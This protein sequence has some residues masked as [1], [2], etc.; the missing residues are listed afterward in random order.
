MISDFDRIFENLLRQ[1]LSDIEF[2]ISF[3]M[4]TK[5]FAPI[6]DNKNT[7]N[8]YLY[9][10]SENRE[11]RRVAPRL[12]TSAE[13]TVFST[14]SLFRV[15]LSYCITAWSPAQAIPSIS[16]ELDEHQLLTQVL[17][18]LLRYPE[19]PGDSDLLQG[20][21]ADLAIPI[22]TSVAMPPMDKKG[23][24][25]FWNA[26]G[27]HLRPSLT[28]EATIPLDYA[29]G[30]VEVGPV[31]TTRFTQYAPSPNGQPADELIQI[32][33]L[34][35]DNEASPQPIPNAWVLLNE[36]GLTQITD[37]EGRF[38]FSQLHQGTYHL[39]VR[40]VGFDDGHRPIEVPGNEYNV[41]L[42]PH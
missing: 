33:G 31:V 9:S 25:D 42:T 19:I 26:I 24:S 1:E 23:L 32:G 38:S 17:A 4:P 14:P 28:Y 5:D 30:P 22:P 20:E 27:G 16:P 39:Q 10:I 34:V 2:D 13:G 35:T 40:A 12:Q 36:T 37:R 41:R 29:R 3:A 18:A 8:C 21:L 7:L 11:L 15:T 6:S